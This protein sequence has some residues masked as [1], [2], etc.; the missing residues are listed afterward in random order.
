[1]KDDAGETR[2]LASTPAGEATAKKLLAR[3]QVLSRTGVPMVGTEYPGPSSKGYKEQLLP[4]ICEI[5]NETGYFLPA[6]WP[7]R[8][9]STG[10]E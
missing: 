10:E 2:N 9:S 1:M 6:D 3:L 7:V 5:A 4:I 8:A